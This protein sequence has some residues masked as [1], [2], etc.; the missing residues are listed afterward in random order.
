MKKIK[1]KGLNT[2]LSVKIKQY[3]SD[4]DKQHDMDH[5]FGK[6]SAEDFNRILD[7]IESE[8]KIDEEIW[9]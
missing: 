5:L 7:K 3:F 6:W 4:L 1:S 8:R 2:P 9:I